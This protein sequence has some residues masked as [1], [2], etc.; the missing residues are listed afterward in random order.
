M[1]MSLFLLAPM[2]AK[3]RKG[4]HHDPSFPLARFGLEARM[5]KIK[6]LFILSMMVIF[7]AVA[8][9]SNVVSVESLNAGKVNPLSFLG[10]STTI[11]TA[12]GTDPVPKPMPLPRLKLA[13]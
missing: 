3:G 7:A 6:V 11:L 8:V 9:F 1:K 12:D 4:E 2:L 10:N 13:S 5:S